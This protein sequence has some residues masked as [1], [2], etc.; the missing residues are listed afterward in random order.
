MLGMSWSR[1]IGLQEVGSATGAM[2]L[3]GAF[4][5]SRIGSDADRLLVWPDAFDHDEEFGVRTVTMAPAA[6]G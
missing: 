6:A 2:V 5:H 4:A 3:G 1:A